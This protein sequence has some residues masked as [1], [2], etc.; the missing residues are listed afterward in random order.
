MRKCRRIN[1]KKQQKQKQKNWQKENL[2]IRNER[3]WEE[4]E[5]EEEEET[6]DKETKYCAD[7]SASRQGLLFPGVP[8]ALQP[9]SLEKKKE[10]KKKKKKRKE[11]KKKKDRH[12][13]GDL[14]LSEGLHCRGGGGGGGGGG[15][16]GDGDGGRGEEEEEEEGEEEEEEEEE[17][18]GNRISSVCCYLIK[19]HFY[20]Q[21]GSVD[22]E[23]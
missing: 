13:R 20:E 3:L 9:S 7:C 17:E 11:K 19:V 15:G 6:G 21:R 2:S 10:K 22:E 12:Y 5:E 16:D 23:E 8:K 4:E 1:A 14:F 18:E